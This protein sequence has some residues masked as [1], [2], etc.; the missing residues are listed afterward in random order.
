MIDSYSVASAKVTEF[1]TLLTDRQDPWESRKAWQGVIA[2]IKAG[3]MQG[4]A[5]EKS[6]LEN[7]QRE[8]RKR[9]ETG[10]NT[11]KALFFTR[12]ASHPLAEKL[13]SEV[14]KNLDV[15]S[16]LGVWKFNRSTASNMQRP[17]RGDLTPF[18]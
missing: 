2:A 4:V 5:D 16:T 8:L 12:E 13:L 6:K 18:G 14:G 9:S 17:W 15:Q 7:A 10:E 3:N 1:H 11:W